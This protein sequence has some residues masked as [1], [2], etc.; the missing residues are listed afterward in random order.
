[1]LGIPV[2]LVYLGFTGDTGI[3]N[4]GAYFANDENWNQVFAEYTREIIPIELFDK[5]HDFELAPVWLISRS[6]PVIEVS[7]Y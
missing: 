3:K 2:V 1:M 6:R 5:K 4:I 7:Q